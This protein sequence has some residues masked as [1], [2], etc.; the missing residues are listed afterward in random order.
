MRMI[1]DRVWQLSGFPRDMFNVYLMGDVLI[2]A[3]TRWAQRRILQQL[4]GRAVRM[5]ALTHCHP[6]HQGSARAVCERLGVPLAC[7]EA[8][9]PAV[10]GRAPMVP[11]NRVM[12]LGLRFWSGPP[13]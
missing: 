7:H 13:H 12:R 10:E 2:D 9:V 5:V 11:A 1:A 6:D 4:R 8:D 3:A